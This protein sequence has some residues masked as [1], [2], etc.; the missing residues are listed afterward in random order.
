MRRMILMVLLLSFLIFNGCIVSSSPTSFF[1]TMD[2]GDNLEFTTVVY[3]ATE[4]V[5]W[6]LQFYGIVV[7][8][9]TGLT[10]TFTPEMKGLYQMTLDTM[11]PDGYGYNRIWIINVQ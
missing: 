2:K 11:G 5:Q 4:N 1:I 7:D 3:P 6:T 10:Y 8:T 9:A